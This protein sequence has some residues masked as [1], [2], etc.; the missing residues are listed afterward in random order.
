MPDFKINWLGT[1]N[2]Y[3]LVS[4]ALT[5]TVV[6]L[7]DAALPLLLGAIAALGFIGR[8]NALSRGIG[9]ERSASA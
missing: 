2:N 9:K 8:R 6:P 5:P 1:K 3:D 4:E 7:S